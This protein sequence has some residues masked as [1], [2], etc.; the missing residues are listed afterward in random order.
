MSRANGVF[1]MAICWGLPMGVTKEYE[2]MAEE[3]GI[4]VQ[5]LDSV[6]LSDLIDM[7]CTYACGLFFKRA[8]AV[9]YGKDVLGIN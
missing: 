4:M 6:G 2:R 1:T 5:R 3:L 7:G 8:K 9:Y